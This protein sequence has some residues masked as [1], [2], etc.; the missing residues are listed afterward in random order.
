MAGQD[1]SFDPALHGWPYGNNWDPAIVWSVLGI[2]LW[3]QALCG[4]MALAALDCFKHNIA[5]PRNLQRPRA[6]QP[7][8]DYT[9]QRQRDSL[10]KMIPGFSRYVAHQPFE[11]HHE[12]WSHLIRDDSYFTIIKK[13]IA[14]DTPIILGLLNRYVGIPT[15]DTNT[16]HQVLVIGWSQHGP[17][18]TDRRIK[19]YDPNV[20]GQPVIL[21][22]IEGDGPP[23]DRFGKSDYD[24]YVPTFHGT[25]ESTIRTGTYNF[26]GAGF[27]HDGLPPK[28][29]PQTVAPEPQ[30]GW[31]WC[32][33]CQGL[34]FTGQGH[35]GVCAGGGGHD[36]AGSGLYGVSGSAGS[37]LPGQ[38]QWRWCLRCQGLWFAG[39]GPTA[40]CPAGGSHASQ[41]SGNYYLW[42]GANSSPWLQNGWRWCKKCQGLWF[43]E[44]ATA[45]ACPSGQGHSADGSGPYI[46]SHR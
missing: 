16:H 36:L 31:R 32:R 17:R 9:V 4:G 13:Y 12:R 22:P 18:I 24:R 38:D 41:G 7:L 28:R 11:S 15:S 21:V 42:H 35:A 5:I 40:P 44:N 43:A 37:L 3:S 46:L 14:K 30:W 23:L 20:P 6:G 25:L 2:P 33:K 26:W 34:W 39:N 27:V 45:G 29:P 1:T 8:F 19:I 10:D